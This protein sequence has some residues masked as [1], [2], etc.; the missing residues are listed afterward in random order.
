MNNIGG[1]Y[2]GDVVA[3]LKEVKSAEQ[4]E[5]KQDFKNSLRAEMIQRAENLQDESQG[6]ELADFVR[7]WKFALGII[8]MVAVVAIVAA[9][10]SQIQVIMQ[11]E[12]IIPLEM[13]PAEELVIA[14]APFDEQETVLSQ[15]K[16][17]PAYQVMPPRENLEK[18]YVSLEHAAS[19]EGREEIIEIDDVSMAIDAEPLIFNYEPYQVKALEI[20]TEPV[21]LVAKYYTPPERPDFDAKIESP[22]VYYTEDRAVAGISSSPGG[23]ELVEPEFTP[24][25]VES[26]IEEADFAKAENVEI[27]AEPVMVNKSIEEQ[28]LDAQQTIVRVL[29]ETRLINDELREVELEEEID[30]A[31]QQLE[32][33]RGEFEQEDIEDVRSQIEELGQIKPSRI[34]YKGDDRELIV[35][36]VSREFANDLSHLS[37]DYLIKVNRLT[38]SKYKVLLYENGVLSVMKFVEVVGDKLEVVT[39][40]IYQPFEGDGVSQG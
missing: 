3:K 32:E 27:E 7:R 8:P 9:N 33:L 13:E 25:Y 38:D 6:F 29:T 11:G 22:V 2:F 39:Q 28:K 34:K 37:N 17:F 19:E 20:E 18:Y 5:I 24:I 30:R 31:R 12:E 23:D 16:T 26:P 35:E 40:A 10:F 36:L 15:V 21:D 14:D 4:I 1:K